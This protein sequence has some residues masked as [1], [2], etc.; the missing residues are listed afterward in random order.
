MTK[1]DTIPKLLRHSSEKYGDGKVA[2]RKKDHGIWM[3]Y[4]WRDYYLK[5]K[6]FSLGLIS[7]GLKH[8]YKISILGDSDPQWIWAEIAAQAAGASVVGIYS[9]SL[10]N[11]VKY[12]ASHSDSTIVVVQD[13]EQVDKILT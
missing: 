1:S 12:I 4:T 10:P 7:L 11:E 9:D 5:V 3:E 8:N 2:M 13:Q 6:Y